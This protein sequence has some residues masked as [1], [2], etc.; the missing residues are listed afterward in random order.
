MKIRYRNHTRFLKNFINKFNR[1]NRQR[2]ANDLPLP[3]MLEIEPINTC[4]LRCK[5]CHHSFIQNEDVEHLNPYLIEKL[6]SVKGIWVK[7]GSN[8]EPVMHPKFISIMKLLSEKDCKIDLTTNGTLL[9]KK[10][11]DHLANCNIRNITISFD[12]V[13]KKNYE[14][15]RRK[16]KFEPTIEKIQ[17][18]IGR[19][20]HGDMFLA[21]NAVL[22]RSNIDEI[23]EMINFWNKRNIHQLR[24]IFMV[25]RSLANDFMGEND[26]LT[27]SLYPIRKKAFK[28]LDEAAAHVLSNNLK[29]TLSSPYYKTS[30]IRKVFPNNLV[31]NI[32]KSTNP[33]S[34]DYFNPSHHYQR[35]SYPGMHFDCRSP[36]VFAR[37]LY[38]GDVDLCYQ[39]TIGNLNSNSLENIWYG[40]RAMQWRQKVLEDTSICCKCDYFR[41]CLSSS[42]IDINAKKNYF[43]QDLIRDAELILMDEGVK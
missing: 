10:T 20:S 37:I 16:A 43:Q 22:C 19:Y 8:F 42:E 21:I 39:Y 15:L 31:G 18:F 25:V 1:P 2:M 34:K 12:S 26:L 7:I 13:N 9:T 28:K 35:G 24:L 23:I 30:K 33:L 38:N 41:F 27:E 6:N 36:F 4:N 17:Y 32:V 29:I 11:T 5:M 40:R 14:K 3:R